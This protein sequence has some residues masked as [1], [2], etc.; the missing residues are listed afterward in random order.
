MDP[1]QV[2]S[3]EEHLAASSKLTD[4]EVAA[5]QTLA[6]QL[7]EQAVMPIL[8]AGASVD[9]GMRVAGGIG[10]D[11]LG[12][13]AADQECA[14]H[15]NGLGHDLGRIADA[16][17]DCKKSQ[18][19]VLEAVGMPDKSLWP[20]TTEIDPHCCALQVLARAV[21][22]HEGLRQAF[23]F[24]YDCCGEAALTFEGFRSSRGTM[25]GRSWLDHAHIICSKEM[26]QDTRARD[27]F[28]FV[29]AHGCAEHY[30]EAYAADPGSGVEEEIVIRAEQIQT[31]EKRF[32]A[33]DGLRTGIHTCILLLV[34]FSGQDPATVRELKAVLEDVYEKSAG[35]GRP[36][37][38]VIDHDPYTEALRELIDFG[39]G[40]DGR[41]DGAV[42][43]ICTANSTTTAVLMVLLAEMI[44]LKLEPSLTEYGL[45]LPS[46]L[47]GRLGLL[48]VVGPA[49][50]RWS[51]SLEHP[52][53]H[54]D[55]SQRVNA[56]M[57]EHDYVPLTYVP[58]VTVR[59][60]KARNGLRGALGLTEPEKAVDLCA[61]RG[62]VVNGNVAFLPI[63]V[64]FED[65]Q[66]AHRQ[67]ELKGARDVLP[68]PRDLES[69]L[70]CE[71]D[72]VRRGVSLATGQEVPVP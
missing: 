7:N 21:R 18:Q 44:A 69:I 5:I 40:P 68:W 46:D 56:Q 60:L 42:T 59:G 58:D 23:S 43:E 62:F 15:L 61:A 3:V 2:R 13:Y 64:R 20:S 9:C 6:A 17:Y 48:T 52:E 67:G 10:E 55:Y 39:V 72:G 50:A 28:E 36:R 32:W 33:R 19:A 37:L 14:P 27:G 25:A 26:F 24:N 49:V 38:V 31:W 41:E 47:D 51:F 16:I 70:V 30:R 71:Q 53:P 63:G 57:K 22:E 29:K 1:S 34:G 4:G 45:E 12:I 65:I 8:G 35:P 54:R 11:L 66:A